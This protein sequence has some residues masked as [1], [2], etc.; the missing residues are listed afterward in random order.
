M[1]ADVVL[2]NSTQTFLIRLVGVVGRES[3]VY[4]AAAQCL[5]MWY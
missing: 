5:L 2:T 1:L 4:G 3:K